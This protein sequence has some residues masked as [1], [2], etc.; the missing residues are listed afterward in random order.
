MSTRR[1]KAEKQ[2]AA[3][4]TEEAIAMLSR[5]ADLDLALEQAA[6]E[7]ERLIAQV[8]ADR[9]ARAEPL[10]AEMKALFNQLKPWWAVSH[11]ALTDGRRKSI[12]LGG[13]QIGHRTTTPRLDTGRLLTEAELIDS[14]E[15]LGFE[16]WAIRVRKELDK[17]ALIAA[18]RRAEDVR[19]DGSPTLEAADAIA[20]Q[21]LGLSVQQREEFFI[22]RIP[23]QDPAV[24]QM[25]SPGDEVAL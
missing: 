24:E 8:R 18:L 11:E 3:Q 20:L 2:A 9:D 15:M 10:K 7:A 22:A 4:T 6:A 5:F 13:C 23:P 19:P 12:E 16:A 1:R 14:L 17:P 21:G 25:P